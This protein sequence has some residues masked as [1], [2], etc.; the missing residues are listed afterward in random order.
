MELDPGGSEITPWA[1]GGAKLLNHPGGPPCAF[2]DTEDVAVNTTDKIPAL[3]DYTIREIHN[4]QPNTGLL[5]KGGIPFCSLTE[6]PKL[7]SA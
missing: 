7:D 6:S 2:L 4:N 1:E 5:C 3:Q